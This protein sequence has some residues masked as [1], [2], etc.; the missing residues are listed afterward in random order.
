MVL[1]TA[2]ILYGMLRDTIHRLQLYCQYKPY[3]T[4]IFRQQPRLQVYR[5][6]TIYLS[7]NYLHLQH[8]LNTHP[9]AL[10]RRLLYL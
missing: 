8:A 2:P 3:L 10:Y 5:H 7:R 1:A 6:L 4:Y 9:F